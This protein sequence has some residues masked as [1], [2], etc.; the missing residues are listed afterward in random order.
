MTS[1]KE[2]LASSFPPPDQ[3]EKLMIEYNGEPLV[4]CFTDISKFYVQ[5][6]TSQSYKK[7]IY[8][9]K[10]YVKIIL[11]PLCIGASGVFNASIKGLV[12]LNENLR[13]IQSNIHSTSL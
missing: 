8:F 5:K 3:I 1:L 11:L 13:D 4:Y 7:F 10:Y 12:L 2:L 9:V 6:I